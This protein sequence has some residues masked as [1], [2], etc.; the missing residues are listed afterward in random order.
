MFKKATRAALSPV[1]KSRLRYASDAAESAFDARHSVECG[2]LATDAAAEGIT[3]TDELP[4]LP[5]QAATNRELPTSIERLAATRTVDIFF[6]LANSV[7]L[8]L[9]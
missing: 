4:P 6:D 5:L 2:R 1:F 9:F 7:R 3:G 8:S